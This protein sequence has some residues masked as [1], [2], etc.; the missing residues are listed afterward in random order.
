MRPTTTVQR[1]RD[2]EAFLK[3]LCYHGIADTYLALSAFYAQ[4]VS[5]RQ[6]YKRLN[7]FWPADDADTPSTAARWAIHTCDRLRIDLYA[8]CSV[9]N[10]TPKRGRGKKGD[11]AG[12]SVLWIDLDV[13]PAIDDQDVLEQL[14]TFQPKPSWVHHSGSGFHALWALEKFQSDIAQLEAANR[15]L[16]EQ[17]GDFGADHCY[18]AT[19]ILR[20]PGTSNW[21]STEDST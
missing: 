4:P 21:K 5:D 16:V 12:S 19:R 10:N 15:W 7:K 17:F 6:N 9:L 14:A 13:P 20:I 1:Q 11:T 3:L 8:R 18:D 2:A